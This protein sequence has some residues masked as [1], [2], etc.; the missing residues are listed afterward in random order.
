MLRSITVLFFI[1]CIAQQQLLA[2]SAAMLKRKAPELPCILAGSGQIGRGDFAQRRPNCTNI[3]STPL[4][5]ASFTK[6]KDRDWELKINNTLDKEVK[7][8]LAIENY[9]A[10]RKALGSDSAYI[11][12]PANQTSSRILK[13]R[14]KTTAC[15]VI[16]K[17]YELK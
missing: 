13:V 12:V 4:V 15:A 6:V 2:E 17:K 10:D 14:N 5:G 3:F 9:S 11:S 7:L 1:A 8:T 16:L